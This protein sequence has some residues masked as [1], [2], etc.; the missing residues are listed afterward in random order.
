MNIPIILL[1]SPAF[2]KFLENGRKIAVAAPYEAFVAF[3]RSR[4][5]ADWF[6]IVAC[7]C[8][9]SVVYAD[10]VDDEISV[11]EQIGRGRQCAAGGDDVII[12]DELTLFDGS[13]VVKL[14][15]EAVAVDALHRIGIE[16]NAEFEGDA[17]TYSRG[18]MK[19]GVMPATWRCDDSPVFRISD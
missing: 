8:H 16:R 7:G 15:G 9:L 2:E 4:C 6:V 18:E 11:C 14:R 13:Q 12:D 5:R 17:F 10:E 1:L 19:T 3:S